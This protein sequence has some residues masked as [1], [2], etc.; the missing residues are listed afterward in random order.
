MI[1][2]NIDPATVPAGTVQLV[3]RSQLNG[4]SGADATFAPTDRRLA[5]YFPDA[6]QGRC[7]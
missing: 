2:L 3:V 7:S 4:K 5:I 1:V 6:A